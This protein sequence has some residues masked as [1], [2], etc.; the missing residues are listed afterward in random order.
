MAVTPVI[1]AGANE[2]DSILSLNLL[3]FAGGY[4]LWRVDVEAGTRAAS[5]MEDG[6]RR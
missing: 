3:F 1:I 2:R 4:L 6:Y 5:E